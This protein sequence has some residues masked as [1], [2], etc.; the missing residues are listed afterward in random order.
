MLRYP[1]CAFFKNCTFI[2]PE[3]NRIK[4]GCLISASLAHLPISTEV[5]CLWLRAR[6]RISVRVTFRIEVRFKVKVK[7]KDRLRLGLG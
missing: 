4:Q 7:V 6:V 3:D 2:C 1:L 5:D